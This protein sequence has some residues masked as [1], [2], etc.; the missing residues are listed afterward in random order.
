[1][2]VARGLGNRSLWPVMAVVLESGA[3]YS[4]TLLVLLAAYVS[5][6]FVQYIG[7]YSY[8]L[9]LLPLSY[10]DYSSTRYASPHHCVF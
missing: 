3:I 2:N 9:H 8:H 10:D 6:S 7:M 1:M 5:N 4:S